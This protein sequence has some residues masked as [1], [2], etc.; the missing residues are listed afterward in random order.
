MTYLAKMVFPRG[1]VRLMHLRPNRFSLVLAYAVS[2]P[3]IKAND[4]LAVYAFS[5][6]GGGEA[7][8][9]I[10]SPVRILARQSSTIP[11]FEL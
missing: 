2:S 9:M 5:C 1:I 3:D 11:E 6:L 4:P 10:S 8:S 7:D